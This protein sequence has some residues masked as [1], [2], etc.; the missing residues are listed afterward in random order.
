MT[1]RHQ[2]FPSLMLLFHCTTTLL[3]FL[4]PAIQG[5]SSSSDPSISSSAPRFDVF[6]KNIVGPY[7]IPGG[8]TE[9]VQVLG[10][11]SI[12]DNGVTQSGPGFVYF[13]CGSYC[14]G[15]VDLSLEDYFTASFEVPSGSRV[16][17]EGEITEDGELD[18]SMALEYPRVEPLDDEDSEV[19]FNESFMLDI[20]P[21][22][23]DFTMYNQRQATIIRKNNNNKNDDAENDD[24]NNES[25][26]SSWD[27]S[28]LTWSEDSIS[29]FGEENVAVTA[30]G[31][32][33]LW[34]VNKLNESRGFDMFMGI[35]CT[36]TGSIKNFVRSYN[37][38]GKL[39]SVVKQE[40]QLLPPLS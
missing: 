15:P 38:D 9:S 21:S 16:Y 37:Y 39:V 30:K 34:L 28:L 11:D 36:K 32:Y 14:S 7:H 22:F 2:L 3:L 35:A 19:L 23:P 13:E 17:V 26:E 31:P 18:G 33:Q 4:I 6:S 40:G 5:F 1:M 20:I 29:S 27:R 24:N 10:E 25:D 12:T 8:G